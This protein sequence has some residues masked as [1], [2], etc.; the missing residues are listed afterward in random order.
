M[1]LSAFCAIA[2]F[3]VHLS[4]EGRGGVEWEAVSRERQGMQEGRYGGTEN[5]N[6]RKV[7][8]KC[9]ISGIIGT[10]L[11]NYCPVPYISESSFQK[12]RFRRK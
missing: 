6:A 4:G 3:F 7:V 1:M 2:K 12:Q 5:G 10:S 9:N 11:V 8:Q